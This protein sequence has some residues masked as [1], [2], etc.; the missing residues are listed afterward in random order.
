MLWAK[1]VTQ[2]SK[3]SFKLYV[4]KIAVSQIIQDEHS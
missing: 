3:S 4:F 2:Y 1:T